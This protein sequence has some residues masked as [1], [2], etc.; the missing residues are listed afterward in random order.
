[1]PDALQ[2]LAV[3]QDGASPDIENLLSSHSVFSMSYSNAKD[4][5]QDMMAIARNWK[6][7]FLGESHLFFYHTKFERWI[8]YTIFVEKQEFIAMFPGLLNTKTNISTS[9]R[10]QAGFTIIELLVVIAL[11]VGFIGFLLTYV[12]VVSENFSRYKAQTQLNALVGNIRSVYQNFPNYNGISNATA[13]SMNLVPADMGNGATL[14]NKFGGS[15]VIGADSG[16]MAGALT[17]SFS[18]LPQQSCQTM[19]ND[20]AGALAVEASTAGPWANLPITDAPTLAGFCSTSSNTLIWDY[21]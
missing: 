10:R 15:V 3:G 4:I 8:S 19:V 1:M 17:I 6:D 2:T 9:R 16:A 12:P 21:R 11:I 20:N 14:T 13:S 5:L 18:G 7:I